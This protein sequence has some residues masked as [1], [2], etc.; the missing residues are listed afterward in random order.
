[1]KASET[2]A[3]RNDHLTYRGNVKQGRHGW[4]RLTPAYSLHVVEEVLKERTGSDFA[5]NPF[6]GTGTTP[7]AS[8][9][10]GIPCH[11]VDVNPFLVWL[12]NVKVAAYGRQVPAD[13]A[14]AADEIVARL[15]NRG[16]SA[17]AWVPPLHQ[18]EK[19]W[20]AEALHALARLF[21][22]IQASEA[23]N[24]EEVNHLLRIAFCRTMIERAHVTFGHQSMSFK[25]RE[26]DLFD[27]QMP[28]ACVWTVFLE[29][30]SAI[31]K[32]LAADQPAAE[33]RVFQG[34]A[35]TVHRALPRRDYTLVITSPPYPNRMS[36]IRELRPY[37][38]WLGYLENGRQAGE[39]DWQA[40]GGTW[41]CAT[42]KL[43][44]W[45]A[46]SGDAVPFRDFDELVSRIR[47]R[48]DIL[49]KYVHRY[50]EDAKQH[51]LSLMKALKRGASC[52]YIVGNSKFYDT[53][54]PVEQIYAA[55]FAD[56]GYR[57]VRIEM[58]RKRTSKKELFEYIVHARA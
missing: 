21:A 39:L 38:Y 33:A 51:I 52:H 49:G 57:D 16:D 41:G 31:A 36:Y 25:R 6:S 24:S 28:A 27:R 17:G 40:I 14:G 18:I 34:D 15:E 56:A 50:F 26:P 43:E 29:S 22:G 46:P 9:C 5:L 37:M 20:D 3:R 4:L 35:R 11:A 32:S 2:S 7:L 54:V 1:M 48:H 19:W 53:I 44:K 58:L 8:A 42:S 10:A 55:L 13:L 30:A 23:S 12:G 45:V 47:K